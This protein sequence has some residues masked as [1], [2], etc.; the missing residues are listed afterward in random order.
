VIYIDYKDG[1][2]DM[3]ENKT[4]AQQEVEVRAWR[5]DLIEKIAIKNE[6]LKNL[7]EEVKK[8]KALAQQEFSIGTTIVDDTSI[9]IKEVSRTNFDTTTFKKD[10]A[11]LYN[12]YSSVTTYKTVS[13]VVQG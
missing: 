2:Q 6:L 4:V 7:E 11:Q 10:F 13:C 1:G 9:T 3:E 12:Q 8:L 5:R